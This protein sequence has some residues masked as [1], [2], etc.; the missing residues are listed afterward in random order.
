MST[1]DTALLERAR[2]I[3]PLIRDARD[4]VQRERRDIGEYHESGRGAHYQPWRTFA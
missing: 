1:R 2:R 3:L 4:A